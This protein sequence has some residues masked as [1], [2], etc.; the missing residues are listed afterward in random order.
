MNRFAKGLS[1]TFRRNLGIEDRVILVSWFFGLITGVM[2]TVLGILAI[3]ILGTTAS[4]RCSVTYWM[5][6]N[7]MNREEKKSLDAK[8]IRYE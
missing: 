4:A 8:A 7:T 3:M 6:I 2:G 5:D 1:Y